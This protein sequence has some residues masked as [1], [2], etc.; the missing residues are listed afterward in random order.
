VRE[1]AAVG[2]RGRTPSSG[3]EGG[4]RDAREMPPSGHEGGRRD[5]REGAAVG[6]QA[7]APP[8]LGDRVSYSSSAVLRWYSDGK[9]LDGFFFVL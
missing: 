7:R 1:G 6:I 2:T 4:R 5:A 3:R 8:G 9:S